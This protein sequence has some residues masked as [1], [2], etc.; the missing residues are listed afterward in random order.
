[1]SG[2]FRARPINP[3]ER[4]RP[5]LRR[6]RALC[7]FNCG[8]EGCKGPPELCSSA[9]R[10]DT[11]HD[12]CGCLC[13]RH[14]RLR[15]WEGQPTSCAPRHDS[16]TVGRWGVSCRRET[17]DGCRNRSRRNC[18]HTSKHSE[19]WGGGA[20]QSQQVRCPAQKLCFHS[21]PVRPS[22]T[23]RSIRG[24]CPS[25]AE[26]SNTPR[27]SAREKAQMQGLSTAGPRRK[28]CS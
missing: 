24:H 25:L 15:E 1:L 2:V 9:Q 4:G 3:L 20:N 7:K 10:H 16:D 5:W 19:S 17:K 23:D 26:L 13:C 21:E 22:A 11:I 27:K 28:V 18:S 6:T 14:G 8:K 12:E